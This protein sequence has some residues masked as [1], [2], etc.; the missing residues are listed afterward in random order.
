M[1]ATNTVSVR[2]FFGRLPIFA[3]PAGS[4]PPT[5]YMFLLLSRGLRSRGRGRRSR[6]RPYGHDFR[7]RHLGRDGGNRRS[8][9]LRNRN[10]NRSELRVIR[11]DAELNF[12]ALTHVESLRENYRGAESFA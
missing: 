9:G 1:M 3:D 10:F 7:M 8:R 11:L 6:R 4:R 2:I 12:L 5:V